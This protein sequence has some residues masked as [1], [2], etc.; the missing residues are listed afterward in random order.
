MKLTERELKQLQQGQTKTASGV[1][2]RIDNCQNAWKD[3]LRNMPPPPR[4]AY[5]KRG[6]KNGNY[7]KLERTDG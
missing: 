4:Y 1:L 2:D 3:L 7:E 6:P 5:Q